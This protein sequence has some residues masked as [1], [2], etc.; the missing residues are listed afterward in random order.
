MRAR[1]E[2]LEYPVGQFRRGVLI[3]LEYE[4]V[5]GKLAASRDAAI[6]VVKPEP[7]GLRIGLWVVIDEHLSFD[8]PAQFG[9]RHVKEHMQYRV[10]GLRNRPEDLVTVARGVSI[11]IADPASAEQSGANGTVRHGRCVTSA[12][13]FLAD[14]ESS[15]L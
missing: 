10:T 5:R 15:C 6:D 2:R 14:R 3:A 7:P 13:P 12:C 11:S 1:S 4:G 8:A 9:R